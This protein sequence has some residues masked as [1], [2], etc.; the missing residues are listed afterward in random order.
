M[1]GQFSTRRWVVIATVTTMAFFSQT[2][3]WAGPCPACPTCS[4]DTNGDNVVN[5]LDIQCFV[6][7][8]L[9]LAPAVCFCS[10]KA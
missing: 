5:G 6:D 9:G 2:S 10:M 3:V 8:F 7:C 4:G 1:L